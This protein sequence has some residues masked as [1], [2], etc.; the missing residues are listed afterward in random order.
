MH[1][2]RIVHEGRWDS[3]EIEELRLQ[4]DSKKRIRPAKSHGSVKG[5]LYACGGGGR[6][7][8]YLFMENSC[9]RIRED[10]YQRSI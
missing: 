6:E 3:S 1:N 2:Q 7:S 10:N 9:V 5:I 4:S 8:H